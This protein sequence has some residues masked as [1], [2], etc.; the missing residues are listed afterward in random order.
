[1]KLQIYMVYILLNLNPINQKFYI[2]FIILNDEP[3]E[4]LV[5][6]NTKHG[7][8][9]IRGLVKK[10]IMVITFIDLKMNLKILNMEKIKN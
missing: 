8:L 5:I 7:V 3:N 9:T 1:M 10:A 2:P 6:V 4:I